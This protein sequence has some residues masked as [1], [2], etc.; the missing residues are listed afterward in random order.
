VRAG[1]SAL[2]TFS[3]QCANMVGAGAGF[4]PRFPQCAKDEELRSIKR[5]RRYLAKQWLVLLRPAFRY[6]RT[7]DAYVLRAV[8]NTRGPVLRIDRRA[9]RK[10]QFDGADRRRHA[11]LA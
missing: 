1:A 11:G 5:P 8:G 3:L 4:R 7:R 2:R 9:G 6:S 10:R